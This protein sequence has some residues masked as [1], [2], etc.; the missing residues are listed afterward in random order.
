MSLFLMTFFII[1]FRPY[2]AYIVVF[3]L[4]CFFY[5]VRYLNKNKKE[6]FEL[7]KRKRKEELEMKYQL[8]VK[9]E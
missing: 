4:L 5:L 2:I 1:E 8:K 6:K 3:S 7:L 9:K